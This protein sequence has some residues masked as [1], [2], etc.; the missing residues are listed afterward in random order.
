ML[1]ENICTVEIIK[2]YVR[3]GICAGWRQL[4]AVFYMSSPIEII[5]WF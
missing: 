1:L 2:F 3:S 5:N 4:I